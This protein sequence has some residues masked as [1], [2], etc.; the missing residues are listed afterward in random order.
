[1]SRPTAIG[2]VS[3]SLRNLLLAEM[4]LSPEVAVTILG[5]DE[6]GA[7]RRINLFLYQVQENATL[8][9]LDWQAKR[10]G[11]LVP[12]PLS[13]NL[14]YLMT[15]YAQ[16]DQ[17]TG[18]ATRHEI[19]GDVMRVFH[20]HPVVPEVHLAPGLQDAREEIRI[21]LRALDLEELSR[22]WTTFSEPFRLSVLYE[23]AVVQ[24]D[25]LPAGE[26]TMAPRVRQIGVPEVR[27]PFRP[28]TIVGFDPASGPTGTAVTVRGTHLEGWRA[29]VAFS[30]RR[31]VQ[32]QEISGDSLGFTVPADLEPGFH[33]VRVDVSHLHRATFFFEVTT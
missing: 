20:E 4:S 17:E 16:N 9:N 15:P 24:L 10:E 32:G 8:K 18:N 29:Y 31:L 1:M 19:L 3:E 25:G 14:F 12:P 23:V 22:V 6:A 30:R 27:V 5:P 13:L 7:T 2:E 11:Q 21:M 28:P 33:E 26:R